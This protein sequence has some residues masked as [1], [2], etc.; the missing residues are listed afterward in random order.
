MLKRTK[1]WCNNNNSATKITTSEEHL[2]NQED[3]K[4]KCKR[5]MKTATTVIVM[6]KEPVI[7]AKIVSINQV[8][9]TVHVR[10]H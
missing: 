5:V 4:N 1:Q 2:H 9:I 6:R 7:G 3:S 10:M 8:L